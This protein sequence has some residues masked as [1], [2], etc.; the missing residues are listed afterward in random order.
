MNL[1]DS[2][3]PFAQGEGLHTS[4]ATI[5]I[6]Y[7]AA[8]SEGH[9]L[10]LNIDT[11]AGAKLIGATATHQDVTSSGASPFPTSG[12]IH[13]G[14]QLGVVVV[15]VGEATISAREIVEDIADLF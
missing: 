10:A 6:G 8:A 3:H 4:K 7:D 12:T 14:P 5:D 13:I 15:P 11:T 9:G 1:I 2:E